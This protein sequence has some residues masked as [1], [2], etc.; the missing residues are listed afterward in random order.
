M[1]PADI[2]KSMM[3]AKLKT[4]QNDFVTNDFVS[5]IGVLPE[6]SFE[7]VRSRTQS[8]EIDR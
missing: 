3:R 1:R 5:L 4:P 7:I 6:M 2:L 8:V